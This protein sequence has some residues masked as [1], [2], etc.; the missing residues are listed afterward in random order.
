MQAEYDARL[1][2]MLAV[3]AAG[4]GVTFRYLGADESER[5]P[6]GERPG[7]ADEAG[8]DGGLSGGGDEEGGGH[9]E[10][11]E[12]VGDEPGAAEGEP[13]DLA[14]VQEAGQARVESGGWRRRRREEGRNACGEGPGG[15]R[16]GVLRGGGGFGRRSAVGGNDEEREEHVGGEGRDG[17]Y[18]ERECAD[19]GGFF[20]GL[21]DFG[22]G[23][24]GM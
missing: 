2:L 3:G 7:D 24:V 9:A 6:E 8:Q 10:G 18:Q 4:L 12:D 13:F 15:A 5:G 17:E 19:P 14:E 20:P 23:E 21:V 22:R 1:I 11:V 16:S